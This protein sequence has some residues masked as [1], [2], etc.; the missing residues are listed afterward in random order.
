MTA[1]IVSRLVDGLDASSS[2]RGKFLR[3]VPGQLVALGVIDGVLRRHVARSARRIATRPRP[4]PPD[5]LDVVDVDRGDL[6]QPTGSPIRTTPDIEIVANRHVARRPRRPRAPSAAARRAGSASMSRSE[7]A[8]RGQRRIFEFLEIGVG[9][10]LGVMVAQPGRDREPGRAA[11]SA[12]PNR[13]VR[14]RSCSSPAD[15]SSL[16]NAS[17]ARSWAVAVRRAVSSTSR[18]RS[19]FIRLTP[20]SARSSVVGVTTMTRVPRS[21][22]C[23]DLGP[24]RAGHDPPD[25]PLEPLGPGAPGVDIV[26]RGRRRQHVDL[27]HRLVEQQ[28]AD[29]F[30]TVPPSM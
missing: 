3:R 19:G 26:Q 16:R 4:R 6:C 18:R 9:I 25:P 10:G 29:V 5:R 12:R 13:P 17:W 2:S 30:D 15:T 8:A 7:P 1:S 22:S 24:H 23:A 11:P 28:V 14:A 27:V 21:R 20:I